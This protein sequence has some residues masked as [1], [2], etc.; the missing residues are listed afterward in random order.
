MAELGYISLVLA[1]V[2]AI[3]AL[4]GFIYGGREKD[5]WLNRNA[6]KSAIGV[7]ILVTV[8]VIILEAA[9]LTHQFE[10]KYVYQY[11]STDMSPIYLFSGLWAGNAGS[12]LFW[13]WMLTICGYILVMRQRPGKREL[14]PYTMAIVMFAQI[15]FIL[16]VLFFSNPFARL[17]ASTF[18]VVPSEGVG[19]N[20]L[21]ENPGM[22]FHPPTLIAGW[23]VFTI[24]FGFAISALLNNKLDN[25]WISQSR[26]WVVIAWLLL[27][28]GNI[29]GAWWAY[30]E[31]SWGG[32]WTW[33]PIENA[34][35]VPWLLSTAFLH[36]MVVQKRRGGFKFWNIGLA[37][38]IFITIILGAFLTRS[39]VL[40][41]KHAFLP[42]AMDSLFLALLIISIIGSIGLIIWRRK[43][44]KTEM[45]ITNLVSRESTFLLSN[46]LFA[47]S[48][49]VILAG[50]L[51]PLLPGSP[52]M[53]STFFNRAVLPLFVSVILLIGL[54][55]ALG[56]RRPQARKIK[57][58]Y[59]VSALLSLVVIGLLVIFGAREWYALIPA[60]VAL[61]AI[62]SSILVWIGD[63]LSRRRALSE[64]FFHSAIN[65]VRANRARYGG[66][67][68]HMSIAIIAI[69][70]IGST[71]YDTETTAVLAP[72]DTMTIKDYEITYETLLGSGDG[73]RMEIWAELTV[74]K[75]DKLIGNM[76]PLKLFHRSYE[77]A[78]S[79]VAIRY[80]LVED[81]YISLTGWEPIDADDLT[82]G[83]WAGFM[84]KVNPL[85]SWI[86]VGGFILLAGGLICYWPKGKKEPISNSEE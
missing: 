54:C 9:L 50:T 35:L 39:G 21:L 78:M 13:T 42:S 6:R 70:V 32:Y 23:A 25:T 61:F 3:F 12:L 65:L 51:S 82:K 75:N 28:V 56:W 74:S 38:A 4:V 49:V 41:S 62:F 43:E 11:T 44:L 53:D 79:K 14:T 85:I 10:L 24:P 76:E 18:P 64:N 47:G 5:S 45:A 77:G 55:T 22:L 59:F 26:R 15:F 63:C 31:L 68:I 27:G 72:G 80:S 8:A 86:W 83:Y 34:G 52:T 71:V 20:P 81:L 66:Y 69:G 40:Q 57:T 36:S 19:M 33:D 48:A 37:A 2:A 29:L 46:V 16:L 67:L 30:A 60:F 17:E 7:F 73:S 1:L 84:A 58:T